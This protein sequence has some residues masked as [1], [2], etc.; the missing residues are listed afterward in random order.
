MKEPGLLDLSGRIP[1]AWHRWCVYALWEGPFIVY[2]GYTN[3]L[4]RRLGQHMGGDKESPL[5]LGGS[6]DFCTSRFLRLKG[7]GRKP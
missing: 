1:L 4:E 2:V 6:F 3:Q 7:R 5:V